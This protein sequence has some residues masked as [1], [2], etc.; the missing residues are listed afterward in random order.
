[1]QVPMLSAS[2]IG[3]KICVIVFLGLCSKIVD[4]ISVVV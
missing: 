1:M 4:I 3:S 2:G